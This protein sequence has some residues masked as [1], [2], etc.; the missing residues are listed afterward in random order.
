MFRVTGNTR[1]LLERRMQED[2][3]SLF[4]ALK[5]D[6]ARAAKAALTG[7]SGNDLGLTHAEFNDLAKAIGG[8]S[9]GSFMGHPLA[10]MPTLDKARQILGVGK[11]TTITPPAQSVPALQ[12][13]TPEEAQE[14]ADTL[15]HGPD[16]DLVRTLPSTMRKLR[17][18]NFTWKRLTI[19]ELEDLG[20]YMWDFLNA[21][22]VPQE[23]K[24]WMKGLQKKFRTDPR[25]YEE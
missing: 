10:G 20:D 22:E 7:L 21:S 9:P 5:N 24:N 16:E 2:K 25:F 17:S 6:D 12:E 1:L 14:L 11:N 18:S 15:E 8:T 13:L 19:N 23:D 3:N 4:K